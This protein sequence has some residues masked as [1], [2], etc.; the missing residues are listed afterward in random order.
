MP[1]RVGVNFAV[2]Y[3]THN[4]VWYRTNNIVWYSKHNIVPNRL[5]LVLQWCRP[6][7]VPRYEEVLIVRTMKGAYE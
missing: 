3:S 7:S 2:W 4:I 6:R 5:V 1:K